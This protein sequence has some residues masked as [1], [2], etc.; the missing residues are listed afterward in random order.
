MR[1]NIDLL[2]TNKG[3]FLK[4]VNLPNLTLT[5]EEASKFYDTVIDQSFW[6]NNADMVKMAKPTK[7]LRGLSL[8][9]G[10]FLHPAS[11]F[12]QSDYKTEMQ[13]STRT[14]TAHK[15]RGAVFID[16][17]ELEEGV[18]GS[19]F[20]DHIMGM[21]A[22]QV[23]NEID[24]AAY[25]S[26]STAFA[27]TNIFSLFSGFRN[28]LMTFTADDVYDAPTYL[29]AS[30][31]FTTAGGIAEL[32]GTT[33]L[34]EFKYS[35][36]LSNLPSKYKVDGMANLRFFG[37]DAVANDYITALSSRGTILGDK[38]ILG[39]V[40]NLKYGQVPIA[41]VPLMP[42]SYVTGVLGTEAYGSGTFADVILTHKSNFVIGMQKDITMETERSA[43]DGGTY[44]FYTIKVGFNIRNP[45][46]V[47]VVHDLTTD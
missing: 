22:K 30:S 27:S 10:N 19:K 25:V 16:D 13:S 34:W 1:N 39:D 2:K 44:I 15:L 7:R 45:E 14:L 24:E 38:A 4:S 31:D 36:M 20:Y 8:G 32:I 47:V 11:T 41:S 9:S 17:D 43:A 28:Y 3:T 26:N 29:D 37:N 40:S 21:V 23:A 42:N 12:S 5:A 46:A 6:K 35:K 33:E 18:E